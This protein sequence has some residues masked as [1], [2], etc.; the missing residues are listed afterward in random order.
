MAIGELLSAIE[1]EAAVEQQALRAEASAAAARI[2]GDAAGARTR[3]LEASLRAFRTAR[4]HEAARRIAAW[5]RRWHG[6]VLAARAAALERLLAATRDAL[7]AFLDDRVA[8]ALLAAGLAA[9]GDEPARVRCSRSI[10]GVVRAHLEGRAGVRVVDDL[11]ASGVVIERADGVV[12][13]EATLEA[14]LDAAWPELRQAAFAE[15]AP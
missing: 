11:D 4:R 14:V 1:R 10:A 13:I 9:L 12:R 5:E 6:A 8:D 15:D 2:L 7:P 3:D